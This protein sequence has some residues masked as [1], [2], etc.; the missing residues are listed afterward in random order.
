MILMSTTSK[1]YL[2]SAISVAIM[3]FFRFIPAPA[4]MTPL[5]MTVVGIFLG[6]IYGWCTTNMIWPSLVALILFGFTGQAAVSATWGG[7]MSNMTVGICFWLMISVGLLKNTGLIQYIADWSVTRKFTRGKPW[8]LMII[9][10]ISAAVCASCLSEVAVTLAFWGLVWAI[11]EEVGYE[12]GSKTA[13]WMTF[14]T[15]ILVGTGGFLLPFKMAVFSNFGFL[16]AGSNGAYDG[17]FDYAAWTLFTIVIVTIMFTVYLLISKFVLRIDLSKLASYVPE[18]SQMHKMTKQQKVSLTLFA[19][20][21]I[22][23]MAP[24]FMPKTFFLAALLGKL[25]T[26]GGCMVIVAITCWIRVDG[27]PLLTFDDLVSKNVIWNIILMFGTALTLCACINS[28]AAGVSAWLKV[29]LDP[30]FSSMSPYAF[31]VCYFLIASVITNFINNAVVGAV[32][33]PLSFSISTAM[34]L[35]PLAVC[36]CMILFADFGVFLPSAS[37]TGALIHNAS[38]WIPKNNLYKYCFLG[39]G[40]FVLTSLIIGWP[41]ANVLFPFAI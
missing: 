36:A 1:W 4:P 31:L 8:L 20:L 14:S 38:G 37:P 32:M 22:I 10:Y 7:I 26:V 29:V 40:L 30:L 9:I 2:N 25:N 19:A 28:E 23:L 11:C 24:S 5:G 15:A 12:K 39:V 21:F 16:A 27:E 33:I 13:T 3:I 41:L 18:E 6:A 34:G 17:S 35:N